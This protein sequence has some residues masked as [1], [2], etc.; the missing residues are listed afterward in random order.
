[1][2]RGTFVIAA[3]ELKKLQVYMLLVFKQEKIRVDHHHAN[4]AELQI[5]AFKGNRLVYYIVEHILSVVP[6]SEFFGW[7]VRV[8]ISLTTT[9]TDSNG[10]HVIEL[11]CG[12]ASNEFNPVAAH[13]EQYE[14]QGLLESAAED[15]K[16]REVFATLSRKIMNSKYTLS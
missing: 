16:C 3:G 2:S 15:A 6:L 12:P 14:P 4:D 8:E 5:S 11:S 1:M 13:M 9:R 10:N 7:A